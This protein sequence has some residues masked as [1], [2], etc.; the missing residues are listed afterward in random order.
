MAGSGSLPEVLQQQ[1]VTVHR[2]VVFNLHRL[3]V[4]LSRL[5][6][7]EVVDGNQDKVG[8]DNL[9]YA[10][11]PGGRETIVARWEIG[12]STV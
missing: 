8:R 12:S 1:T 4:N 9:L 5:A 7:T 2:L 6:G 3:N 11:G 10:E